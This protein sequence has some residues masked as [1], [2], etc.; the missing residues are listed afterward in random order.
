MGLVGIRERAGLMGGAV[1]IE[2]APKQGTTLF[3]HIPA[4]RVEEKEP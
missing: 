1:E 2:S 4:S 3:V